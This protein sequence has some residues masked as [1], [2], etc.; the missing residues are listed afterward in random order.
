MPETKGLKLLV[1]RITERCNLACDYCYAGKARGG[2]MPLST[3]LRLSK[4]RLARRSH[5]NPVHRRR[6]A[7]ERRHYRGGIRIRTGYWKEAEA[8]IQTNGTL[9]TIENCLL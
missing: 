4:G 8:A 7:F 1:L 9:L 6:A 2:D 5:Q 3:A